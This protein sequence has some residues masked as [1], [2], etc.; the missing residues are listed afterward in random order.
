MC[1]LMVYQAISLPLHRLHQQWLWC[2]INNQR[3]L[4]SHPK[5]RHPAL[6]GG[7]RIDLVAFASKLRVIVTMHRD[8]MPRAS[9]DEEAF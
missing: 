4:S 6:P 1:S 9:T 8:R 7:I 3:R 2:R 5:P